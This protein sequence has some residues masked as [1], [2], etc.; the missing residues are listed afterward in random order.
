MAT[1]LTILV[2]AGAPAGDPKSAHASLYLE[3][4]GSG[5][6]G[7]SHFQLTGRH[8]LFRLERRDAYNPNSVAN[9]CGKVP[10]GQVPSTVTK[11]EIRAAFV[12]TQIKNGMEDADWNCR[13]WVGDVLQR[14]I[15][16]KWVT[17]DERDKA[18]DKMIDSC[19]DIEDEE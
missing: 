8:P 17:K 1:Y 13:N 14:M 3:D 7:G 15:V 2:F 12:E 18:L 10:V 6:N 4:A 16:H 11:S 5:K 9:L 19:L